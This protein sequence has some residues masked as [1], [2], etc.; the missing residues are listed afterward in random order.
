MGP[1]LQ[2]DATSCEFWQKESRESFSNVVAELISEKTGIKVFQPTAGR[3]RKLA[4]KPMRMPQ[5]RGRT[6][7]PTA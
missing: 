3:L 2:G 1:G 7:P 5:A 4:V 6:A